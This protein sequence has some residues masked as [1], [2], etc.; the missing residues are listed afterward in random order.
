MPQH[1]HLI[2]CQRYIGYL[3]EAFKAKLGR[4][5]RQRRC[6]KLHGTMSVPVN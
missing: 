3:I 1:Q 6:S 2:S 5:Q 4:T